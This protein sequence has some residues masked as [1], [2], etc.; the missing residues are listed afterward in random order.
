MAHTQRAQAV[1]LK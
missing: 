1:L